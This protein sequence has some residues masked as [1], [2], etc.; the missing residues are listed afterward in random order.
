MNPNIVQKQVAKTFTFEGTK[1]TVKTTLTIF[2]YQKGDKT[3]KITVD[4]NKFL[5]D[6]MSMI[7]FLAFYGFDCKT[8]TGEPNDFKEYNLITA[9]TLGNDVPWAD[10]SRN[11]K[12]QVAANKL[13]WVNEH[14]VVNLTDKITDEEDVLFSNKDLGNPGYQGVGYEEGKLIRDGIDFAK[15]RQKMYQGGGHGASKVEYEDL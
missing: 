5:K 8:I 14:Y 3:L 13:K 2:E 15:Y 4:S 9:N 6:P 1:K 7:H 11:E 12:I 10:M